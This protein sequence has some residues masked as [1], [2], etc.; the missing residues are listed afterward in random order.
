VADVVTK[1]WADAVKIGVF[2]NQIG[3]IT[4]TMW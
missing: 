2:R 3:S 4:N 1:E